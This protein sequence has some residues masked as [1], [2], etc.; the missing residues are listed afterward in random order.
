M[1]IDTFLDVAATDA[2]LAITDHMSDRLTEQ[3][4][5]F[6]I[7][8]TAASMES[9]PHYMICEPLFHQIAARLRP[10]SFSYCFTEN[11]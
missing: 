9:I 4:H 3:T 8:L 2:R 6:S 10:S 5:S 7:T 11:V 1:T